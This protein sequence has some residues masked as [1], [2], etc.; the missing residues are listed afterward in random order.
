MKEC[1]NIRS[2]LPGYLDGELKNNDAVFVSSHL[3]GCRACKEEFLQFKASKDLLTGRARKSL[4]EDYLV[5]RL[6]EQIAGEKQR[7]ARGKLSWLPVIGRLAQRFIPVPAVVA[8]LS[9]ALLVA[10]SWQQ[11]EKYSL[12]EHLLS[13]ASTTTDTALSLILGI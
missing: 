2:L 8:A 4:P 9:I 3:D 10:N 1:L 7:L 13:G 11:A 6:R 5:C 12:D